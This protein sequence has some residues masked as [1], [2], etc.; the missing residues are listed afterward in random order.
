MTAQLIAAWALSIALAAALQE[1]KLYNLPYGDMDS[2]GLF[3]QRP[4]QRW[5]T[6]DEILTPRYAAT[7]FYTHLA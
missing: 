6:K 4:S 1:S 5:G 7:A 2:L 3:Q